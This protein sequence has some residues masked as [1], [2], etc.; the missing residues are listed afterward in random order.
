[1]NEQQA[2][3]DLAGFEPAL[4]TEVKFLGHLNYEVTLLYGIIHILKNKE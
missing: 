1:M 4:S 3:K 2:S